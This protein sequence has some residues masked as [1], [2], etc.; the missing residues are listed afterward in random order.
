[1][2]ALEQMVMKRGV[3]LA[4]RGKGE[5]QDRA[6]ACAKTGLALNTAKGLRIA[7]TRGNTLL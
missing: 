1:M 3:H 5:E 6:R 7:A 2:G 4:A